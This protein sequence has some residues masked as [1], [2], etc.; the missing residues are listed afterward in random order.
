MFRDTYAR[1][2][3]QVIVLHEYTITATLEPIPSATVPPTQV[4][5]RSGPQSRSRSRVLSAQPTARVLPWP[6]CPLAAASAERIVG[7]PVEDLRRLIKQEFT[8]ISTCTHL[9]D[10][11][12]SLA[13]VDSLQSLR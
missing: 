3:G 2:D 12:A 5:D 11:L 1:P 9:N 6:E 7:H 10:L 4:G 8:G 13:Q